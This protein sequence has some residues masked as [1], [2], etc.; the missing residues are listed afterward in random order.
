MYSRFKRSSRIPWSLIESRYREKRLKDAKENPEPVPAVT[1]KLYLVSF[2]DNLIGFPIENGQVVMHQT[3]YARV[4]RKKEKWSIDRFGFDDAEVIAFSD[5]RALAK[6][7]KMVLLGH[8]TS[9]VEMPDDYFTK[10]AEEK[11][12]TNI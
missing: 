10:K 11:S 8:M 2:A 1:T 3:V 6:P 4:S 5:G 12:A 9:M 7:V